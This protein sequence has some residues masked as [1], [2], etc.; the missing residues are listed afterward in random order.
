V[1][2]RDDRIGGMSAFVDFAGTRIERYY[3]FICKPDVTTF[4]YLR[5]LGLE[6]RLRWRPWVIAYDVRALHSSQ[7]ELDYVSD[8][9]SDESEQA[10]SAERVIEV[11][12]GPGR[13]K[14]NDE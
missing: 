6:D 12:Q 2:E 1:F 5:E 11:W 4:K 7:N 3:H 13:N 14:A 10:E 8:R 9:G